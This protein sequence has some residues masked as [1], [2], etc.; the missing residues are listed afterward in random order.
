MHGGDVRWVAQP[1]P[2]PENAPGSKG[3]QALHDL[4]GAVGRLRPGVEP[5]IHPQRD[6]V[7]EPVAGQ[8]GGDKERQPGGDVSPIA[9]RQVQHRQ[10]REKEQHRG[11]QVLLPDQQHRR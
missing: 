2:L 10:E 9:G 7:R 3:Q 1:Q 8:P 5:T 6:P 4:K 11:A